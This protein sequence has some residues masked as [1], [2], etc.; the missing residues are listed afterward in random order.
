MWWY[1]EDYIRRR[2]GRYLGALNPE[3]GHNDHN[4][5]ALTS[6]PLQT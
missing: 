3:D 6:S 1:N 2:S 4:T 5:R